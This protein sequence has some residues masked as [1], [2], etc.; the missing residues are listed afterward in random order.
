VEATKSTRAVNIHLPVDVYAAMKLDAQ[1]NKRS[2][3]QQIA[4]VVERYLSEQGAK[5]ASVPRDA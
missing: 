3:K 1:R 5:V 4:M 2:L